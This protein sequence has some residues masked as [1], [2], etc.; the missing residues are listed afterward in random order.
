MGYYEILFYV[1]DLF[2][3]Y[4]EIKVLFIIEVINDVMDY[5]YYIVGGVIILGSIII[6]YI[7]IKKC[8][9]I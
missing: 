4:L 1:Y 3:N 9:N 6:Y 7:Y 5:I 2:G 8:E